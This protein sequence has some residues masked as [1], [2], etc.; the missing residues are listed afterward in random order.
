MKMKVSSVGVNLNDI[1]L[2]TFVFHLRESKLKW[3]GLYVVEGE[4]SEKE[5]SP[6]LD[7]GYRQLPTILSSDEMNEVCLSKEAF[8]EL[9]GYNTNRGSR[10]LNKEIV[11]RFRDNDVSLKF[12][13]ILSKKK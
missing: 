13:K 4:M 6:Y 8:E 9:H 7:A 11:N 3:F 2:S 1:Q 12:K 10:V 5:I